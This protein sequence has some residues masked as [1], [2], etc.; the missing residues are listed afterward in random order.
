M[1]SQIKQF[2]KKQLREFKTNIK[3]G[4]TIRVLQIISSPDAKKE[5]TQTGCT[6]GWRAKK[7]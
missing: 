7:R 3:A 2:N 4:D 5:K 6:K 1:S